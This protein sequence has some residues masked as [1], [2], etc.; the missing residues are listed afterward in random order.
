MIKGESIILRA[1]EPSDKVQMYEWENDIDIRK[2]GDALQFY[3]SD[4]IE[5]FIQ[6]RHEDIYQSRQVRM[7]IQMK[8]Q[9]EITLGYI[10][11]YDFDPH[12][13]KA[14]IG[15]LIGDKKYRRKGFASEAIGL[16]KKYAGENLL[17]HQLYCYV[18]ETNI[19]SISLFE[20][21]GFIK[22]AVLKDWIKTESGYLD[23]VLLQCRKLI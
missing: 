22:E 6:R 18:A 7:V 23:V 16:L 4:I 19:G 17:L 3:A 12:N 21:C 10:D 11:L 9:K 13:K 14:A 5:D 1:M 8:D 15:I 20:K 2:A